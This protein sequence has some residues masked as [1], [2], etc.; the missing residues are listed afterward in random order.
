[1]APVAIQQADLLA[2]NFNNSRKENAERIYYNDKGSM[3]T[4]GRNLACCRCT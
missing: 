3:A 4:V 2:Y 1:V